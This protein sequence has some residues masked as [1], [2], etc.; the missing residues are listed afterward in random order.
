MKVPDA[1]DFQNPGENK[2]SS[3]FRKKSLIQSPNLQ[4]KTEQQKA[5]SLWNV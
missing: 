1:Q 4:K 5:V 2:S 3:H